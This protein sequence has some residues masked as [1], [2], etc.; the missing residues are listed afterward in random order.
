[1]YRYMF[2]M[3]IKLEHLIAGVDLAKE[4]LVVVSWYHTILKSCLH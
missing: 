2:A 1:M 4:I 3:K